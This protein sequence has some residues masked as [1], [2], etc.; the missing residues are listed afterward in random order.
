M[1]IIYLIICVFNFIMLCYYVIGF[2]KT[3]KPSH[4]IET[5][6][7][8]DFSKKLIE[9]SNISIVISDHILNGEYKKAKKLIPKRD[10][11]IKERDSLME[12]I[13]YKDF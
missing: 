9:V 11:L 3:C 13:P 6:E 2:S 1:K 10:L 4:V 7:Y 12:L 8:K 5:K